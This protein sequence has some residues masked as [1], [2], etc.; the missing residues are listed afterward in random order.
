MSNQTHRAG[1]KI[2]AS[3]STLSAAAAEVVDCLNRIE[4]ISKIAIGIIK[5]IRGR[6]SGGVVVKLT[7]ELSG[8]LV[9]VT[10]KGSSQELRYYTSQRA[11]AKA[12]LQLFVDKR[13]WTFR[14]GSKI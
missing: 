9:Q 7:E 5:P 11:A 4:P 2:T 1:G 6:G 8:M 12:E 3:H 13:G 10:E 14:S